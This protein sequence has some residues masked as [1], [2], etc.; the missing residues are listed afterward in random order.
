MDYKGKCERCPGKI[1]GSLETDDASSQVLVGRGC[2]VQNRPTFP[3]TDMPGCRM[4]Q[5]KSYNRTSLDSGVCLSNI[6]DFRE[7]DVVLFSHEEMETTDSECFANCECFKR[8]SYDDNITK[9]EFSQNKKNISSVGTSVEIP[10]QERPIRSDQ[11]SYLFTQ[12]EDGDTQLHLAIIL[13]S[14]SRLAEKI[15][16]LCPH[17]NLLNV[18]ND[19]LQ[20]PLHLAVITNKPRIVRCLISHGASVASFDH[21]GD[22]PLH[23]ACR[24]GYSECILALT[25]QTFHSQQAVPL[26]DIIKR[27]NYDG[28]TCCHLAL[29]SNNLEILFHLTD[30][31]S[32]DVNAQEGKRGLTV[33]HMASESNNT[34]L[35]SFLLQHETIDVNQKTYDG[36]TALDLAIS[37]GLDEMQHTLKLSGA[38]RGIISPGNSDNEDDVDDDL[39]NFY[40]LHL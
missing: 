35:V 31:C 5:S 13:N 7:R 32:A 6:E 24:L 40:E 23:L 21:N 12:D 28:D 38:D 39:I 22:T 17:A 19:L 33:L 36:R 18:K 29:R 15:I 20:S 16:E 3:K 27:M 1:I 10:E 2:S 14:D 26:K 11:I 4:D 25:D 8:N 9:T 37:R 34:T 30:E